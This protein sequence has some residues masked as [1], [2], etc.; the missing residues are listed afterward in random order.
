MDLLK[1][2]IKEEANALADISEKLDD[3]YVK[4][5]EVIMAASGKIIISG[6]GK[7]GIIGRK[8]AATLSSLGTPS[9]FM[10]S[11]EAIHGD[12]GMVARQ[13]IVILLSNS[14]ETK[15]ILKILPSLKKIGV[16]IISIS[17]NEASTLARNSD[18]SLI[19]KIEKEA[20]HLN[21]SPTSSAVV[22]LAI[23]D[24]L[25][26]TVSFLKEF[27]NKDFLL[28]HPGGSLANKLIKSENEV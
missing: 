13:D 2:C 23:G 11:D 17:G 5:V 6:V 7:S 18:V 26:V 22:M 9:F 24:A 10:H 3:S 8:I 14:G 25:A 16:L 28:F 21:L 15:E 19:Y 27:T 12:L 1:L 20:D 4:A